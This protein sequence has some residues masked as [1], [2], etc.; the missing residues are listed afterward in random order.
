MKKCE[1]YQN[2]FPLEDILQKI[3]ESEIQDI[4]NN[5]DY[6][7]WADS[8]VMADKLPETSRVNTADAAIL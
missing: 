6:T 3:E 1:Y 7:Y 2:L 4:V 5:C 8:I